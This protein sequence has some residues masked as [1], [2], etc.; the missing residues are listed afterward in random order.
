[1]TVLAITAFGLPVRGMGTPLA[2]FARCA[3]I[4]LMEIEAVCCQD[5]A[6]GSCWS[7][8]NME[9]RWGIRIAVDIPVRFR[10]RSGHFVHAH[11][12]DISLSGALIRTKMAL[13][14]DAPLEIEVKGST[15]SS[16]VVRV[17]EGG[18][19]VEWSSRL[20][21]GIERAL[22]ESPLTR[23]RGP[24]SPRGRSSEGKQPIDS[25]PL[26]YDARSGS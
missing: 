6:Q 24:P 17:Q 21:G 10:C 5:R 12:V 7:E 15:I 18:I 4:P 14:R 9:H 23:D 16:F 8:P 3:G 2:A 13:A 1:M 22:L 20:P 26:A 11:L 25:G 19:G